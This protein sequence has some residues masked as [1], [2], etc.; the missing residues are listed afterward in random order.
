MAS[1]FAFSHKLC[2]FFGWK[3]LLNMKKK[4]NIFLTFSFIIA[5]IVCVGQNHSIKVVEIVDANG[6]TPNST[7]SFIQDKDGFVWFGTLNG[8]IRYDGSDFKIYRNNGTKNSLSNNIIRALQI[9]KEGFIWVGT[10][11]GGLNRYNPKTDN[12]T[13]FEHNPKSVNSLSNNNIWTL[14]LDKNEN[15]WIGTLGGGLDKFDKNT[16]R[17]K[18]Y[19]HLGSNENTVSDNDIRSLFEDKNGNIW[20]G[21]QSNGLDMLNP[22][23][24][25][26][27]HYKF[28]ASNKN[29]LPC[30]SIYSIYQDKDGLLWLG[31]NGAG[32]QLLDLKTGIFSPFYK[33]SEMSQIIFGITKKN[34]GNLA[35]ATEH[36]LYIIT[37]S[38][39]KEVRKISVEN[40]PNLKTNRLRGLFVDKNDNLWIAT[41]SGVSKLIENKAFILFTHEAENKNSLAG[42]TIRSVYEDKEGILWIGTLGQGLT[43]Y[44]FE[45]QE[46]I[47]IKYSL[48][49]K[50]LLGSEITSIMEDSLGNFWVSCWGQGLFL[51]DKQTLTVKKNYRHKENSNS[52]SDDRVQAV[53]EEQKGILWVSTE[54]G[55]NR[56]NIETQ[57]W[58][59]FYYDYDNKNSVSGNKFQSKSLV[60]DKNGVVWAGT[61]GDGLNALIPSKKE[62]NGYKILS[63][64]EALNNSN[65]ISASSVISL[66]LDSK[67]NLW[68]G[69][70]GGG[71]DLLKASELNWI[72]KRELRFINYNISKG[73]ANNIIYGILEDINGNIWFSSDSGISKLDIETQEFTNYNVASGLNSNQFFWGASAS[74]RNKDL[75]FGNIDG[76]VLVKPQKLTKQDDS[77][78]LEM[79]DFRF[80]E[81]NKQAKFEASMK[82][83]NINRLKK[84]EIE[85][86][87]AFF[88]I[89]FAAVYYN[90]NSQMRYAYKLQGSGENWNEQVK[91]EVTFNNLKQGD[92]VFMVKAFKPNSK[93][94]SKPKALI[95]IKILPPFWE[96]TWFI[97]LLFIVISSLLLRYYRSKISRFKQQKL[98]LELKVEERTKELHEKN[99]QLQ[100]IN[101]NLAQKREEAEIQKEKTERINK[102]LNDFAYI[103]SHDLKAPLRGISQLATWIS[104]D[105]ADKFDQEGKQQLSMLVERV[106]TMDK[107]IEGVLQY[108]RATNFVG[109]FE[110]I[111]LN[112]LVKEI[113]ELIVPPQ[114]I[115]IE[116]SQLP[117]INGDRVRIM[118]IFQN[119]ISNAIKYMDKPEGFIKINH[120]DQGTHWQFDIEDNGIGI[121][122]KYH[123]SIFNIFQMVDSSRKK[124][125]TGI[126]LSIVKRIVNIY[127]G[128]IWVESEHGKGSIFKFTLSKA[129]G[130]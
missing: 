21:T 61:W 64:K 31:T 15:L 20:I 105:Y 2:H 50:K 67:G 112:L 83:K 120:S 18:N 93:T 79:T 1:N 52:L 68:I 73:L 4:R 6:N 88:T 114:N 106:K 122:L 94:W 118:Q 63:W 108:S 33:N 34:D 62:Q 102:E 30:N 29:S 9:D 23:T 19:N 100:S 11:G 47:S 14:L 101:Q 41:E 13:V 78:Y 104:I 116:V 10:Q 49:Q 84:I 16:K 82:N 38:N 77:L 28:D 91:N 111:D 126:G 8:L 89:K 92:Y 81:E 95:H 76:L 57:E 130:F 107:M 37:A 39:K 5:F 109:E 12:F 44:N 58:T 65:S 55:L 121:P 115:K 22:K 80:L 40:T 32:L 69:T 27:T 74:A 35:I 99:T 54:N 17:F 96:T 127:K 103:I 117:S 45:N 110:L 7:S 59:N 42:K 86:E 71:V 97:T 124:D 56:L 119:L 113:I 123:E 87:D 128:R 46:F 125:S 53:F 25:K 26:I 72:G 90:S 24:E 3:N 98:E 70:F 85:S 60:K 48:V 129:V 66:F 36:G 51:F 75:Y 43:S